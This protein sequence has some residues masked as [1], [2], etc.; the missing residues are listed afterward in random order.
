MKN[1]KDCLGSRVFK[2]ADFLKSE[3][4][5]EP[6]IAIVLGSGWGGVC[7]FLEDKKVIAYSDIEGMPVC[8]VQGH[9]GNFILGK[10]GNKGVIAVQ[11]RFHLYEGKPMEDVVLPIG[12]CAAMGAKTLFLTN[13][14]GALNDSYL[15]GDLMSLS[16]HINFTGKNPLIGIKAKEDFPVF[17]DMTNIYDRMISEIVS[18]ECKKLNIRHQNGIYIQVLGPSYETPSEVRAFARLGADAVGMSTTVEA[19]YARYLGLRIAGLSCI[20]NKGAGLSESALNHKEVLS[21]LE[22][23]GEKFSELL[24]NVFEKI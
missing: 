11:G 7:K 9:S 18:D 23:V 15:P 8:G 22:S 5:I 1:Y 10:I 14:A 2:I 3:S 19:I 13:S 24:K 12:V 6:E 4:D 17:I 21:A 20:T 16:D